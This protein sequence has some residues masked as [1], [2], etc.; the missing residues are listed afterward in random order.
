M[1]RVMVMCMLD[2]PNA[3]VGPAAYMHISSVATCMPCDTSYKCRRCFWQNKEK[4]CGSF[5]ETVSYPDH[6]IF[7]LDQQ[8]CI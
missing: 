2:A 1:A 6:A 7:F 5:I 8:E 4:F 3:K